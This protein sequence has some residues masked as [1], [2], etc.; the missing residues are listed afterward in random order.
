MRCKCELPQVYSKFKFHTTQ[1]K[2]KKKL[3]FVV[4]TLELLTFRSLIG[5]FSTLLPNY[6][7]LNKTCVKED[8]MTAV[9]AW[10]LT[11]VREKF[12]ISDAYMSMS[13]LNMFHNCY[14]HKK[15]LKRLKL[16]FIEIKNGVS[17]I[18]LKKNS[19]RNKIIN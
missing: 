17:F 13:V 1:H 12:G 2:R 4:P 3:Y 16:I 6:Y 10:Y 7:E 15:K 9:P 18:F 14:L 19:T 8:F 5:R 11:W